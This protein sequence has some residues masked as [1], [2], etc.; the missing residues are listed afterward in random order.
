MDRRASTFVNNRVDDYV[1]P[2]VTGARL[3]HS[4]SISPK[5]DSYLSHNT[6]NIK[7]LL[8][9]ASRKEKEYMGITPVA[10]SSARG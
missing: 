6:L 9:M 7:S 10:A 3:S 4:G 1:I 2:K 5:R 8:K